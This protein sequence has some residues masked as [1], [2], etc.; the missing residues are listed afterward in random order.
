MAVGED[1][2]DRD[3]CWG[4]SGVTSES[5]DQGDHNLTDIVGAPA[6]VEDIWSGLGLVGTNHGAGAGAAMTGRDYLPEINICWRYLDRNRRLL[7]NFGQGP[8]RFRIFGSVSTSVENVDDSVEVPG[9]DMPWEYIG[10]Q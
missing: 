4:K 3:V 8:C 9:R 7:E 6:S 2:W 5:D 10:G 1:L